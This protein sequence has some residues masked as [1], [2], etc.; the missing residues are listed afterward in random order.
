[1]TTPCPACDR[2]SRELCG[3]FKA[4]CRG[5]EARAVARSPQFFRVR[6]R[7]SAHD[8]AYLAMLAAAFNV[9]PKDKDSWWPAHLEVKEA[10]AHDAMYE[11]WKACT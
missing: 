7:Q 11:T 3:L 9:N 8:P 1:M 10:F 5:C 4:G 2:A 6:K